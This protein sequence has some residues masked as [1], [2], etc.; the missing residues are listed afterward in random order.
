MIC[1]LWTPLPVDF[2]V[3]QQ[4]AGR[5]VYLPVFAPVLVSVVGHVREERDMYIRIWKI[6]RLDEYDD[7]TMIR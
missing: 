2:L 1:S 6:N 3:R 4:N 5:A 7:D